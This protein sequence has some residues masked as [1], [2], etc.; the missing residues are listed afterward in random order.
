MIFNLNMYILEQKLLD[1]VFNKYWIKLENISSWLSYPPNKELWDFAFSVFGISKEIKWNPIQIAQELSSIIDNDKNMFVSASNSGWYINFFLN[2]KIFLEELSNIDL[3]ERNSNNKTIVV[4]Y[5]GANVGK[6]L[7]IWH[8][9]TPSLGQSI[10]NIYKHL[11]YN[12]ISDSHFWDW[13]GIFGKL[14]YAWKYESEFYDWWLDWKD[15]NNL[16]IQ[17]NKQTIQEN[18]LFKK[19]ML[20]K[21][22][23][24]YLLKLY[25]SSFNFTADEE[26][27]EIEKDSM[28]EFKK[29]SEWDKENVELWKKFTS[30]SIEEVSKQLE[31]ELWVKPQYNIWESFYEWLNL[32]RPN[33]ENYPELQYNMKDIVK[34]LLDKKIASQ[35]ED[36]SV[37]VVFPEESKIPSC[38][39]QKKDWTGLYLTSDL[40]AIKY[41]LDNWKPSKIIYFVDVR[42]QLHLKQAFYIAKNTWKEAENIEL[43]HAFNG[44]IKLKEWAMSTRKWTVIF[45][46]DL[47]EEWYTKTKEILISK[48][49]EL[50]QENIK[51]ITIAAIKYSYL[52]QDR[53]K[54]V[55][56]D[57]DKALNFE[58]NSGPYIQYAYVRASKIINN[59]KLLI[60]NLKEK[61]IELSI[62]DKTIIKKLLEFEC[63]IEETAKK[64]K[65]SILAQYCYELAQEFNSFYVNS[66]KILE[67]K[68]EKIKN[69]KLFL[70]Q[71]TAEILKKWFSILAID[72]PNEM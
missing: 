45:L 36:W 13:G 32:P 41:R 53:E 6:P 60:T 12:V 15:C 3:K 19:C 58:W 48:W 63:K 55:V 2:D 38:V 20:N 22:W 66:G 33:N 29:L 43:F 21:Y 64:Y 34:I 8:L 1:I 10:I 67:E 25:Q 51:A 72:M 39:L 37:W 30:I 31:E 71:I 47:I 28:N 59:Y 23:V 70:V 5:I 54:D 24:E 27:K 68:D 44:F 9:C 40:A 52:S 17:E 42:Q 18:K 46:K 69:L 62:F 57:W 7:H 14:I 4:D 65:P 26:H 49:R 61:N 11:G 35:N 56:F 16:L 50:S